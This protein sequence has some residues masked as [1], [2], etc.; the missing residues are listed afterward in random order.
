MNR[1]GPWRQHCPASWPGWAKKWAKTRGSLTRK[2]VSTGGRFEV[3]PVRQGLQALTGRDAWHLDL[4]GRPKVQARLVRLR[5]N[6]VPVVLAKTVVQVKGVRN[7]WPFWRGLGRRSLGTALF[8]DPMVQRGPLYFARLPARQA[9]IKALALPD[10]C[11]VS[12]WY[13][14]CARYLRK[15]GAT[16][17][18]VFEVFVPALNEVNQEK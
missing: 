8:S 11:P 16:P 3:E 10:V 13:V 5:L 18:W 7:D 6:G 9:W 1:A 2:L 12:G 17:M 4:A 15:P 14:R